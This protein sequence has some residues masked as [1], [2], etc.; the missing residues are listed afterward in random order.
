MR[1]S[2]PRSPDTPVALEP[3]KRVAGQIITTTSAGECESARHVLL[4]G[5]K[6]VKRDM[7]CP[8]QAKHPFRGRGR[9]Q[10]TCLAN[11]FPSN[12]A[13]NPMKNAIKCALLWHVYSGG[14]THSRL[15]LWSNQDCT[16]H[17]TWRVWTGTKRRPRKRTKIA[18]NMARIW[19][20]KCSTCF[21][22]LAVQNKC[23][24]T[25]LGCGGEANREDQV[26]LSSSLQTDSQLLQV[27]RADLDME[28]DYRHHLRR[29]SR[30]LPYRNVL[31]RCPPR[32]E[33]GCG[34]GTT[35]LS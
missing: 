3:V 4:R 33:C 28:R 15:P 2:R 13:C 7:Q 25:R 23:H 20:I 21:Q 26:S 32:P 34:A 17:R 22:Y 5:L 8:N 19:L 10:C 35:R 14:V 24:C 16:G 9:V 31:P 30:C 18:G 12:V 29:K 11:H 1:Q 27:A 6:E